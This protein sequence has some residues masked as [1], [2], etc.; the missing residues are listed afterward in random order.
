MKTKQLIKYLELLDGETCAKPRGCGFHRHHRRWGIRWCILLFLPDFFPQVRLLPPCSLP[1]SSFCISPPSLF[2]TILASGTR[3][4]ASKWQTSLRF[5]V[6]ILLSA[7]WRQ[8]SHKLFLPTLLTVIPAVF[9]SAHLPSILI[10]R[11]VTPSL[12]EERWIKGMVLKNFLC[13]YTILNEFIYVY[14]FTQ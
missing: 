4:N 8:A 5:P 11:Q 7:F 9:F 14:G 13:S 2:H 6:C 3:T 10:N 12:Q 1:P